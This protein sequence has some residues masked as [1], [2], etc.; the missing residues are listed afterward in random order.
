MNLIRGRG[1]RWMAVAMFAGLL[2]AAIACGGDT[3]TVIQTVV[4]EKVVPGETIIQ[5]VVETVVVEKEV[6]IDGELVVQTVIVERTVKGDTV[7]ETITETIIE[8]VTDSTSTFS[9]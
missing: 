7:T 5:T 6:L 2:S 9:Q 8:T 3:E 1:F 4:V